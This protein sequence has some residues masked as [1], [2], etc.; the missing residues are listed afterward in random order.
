VMHWNG[1]TWIKVTSPSPGPTRNSL[2][3]VTAVS[4]SDA[5]AAGYYYTST[6]LEKT[7]VL[8]WNGTAWTKVTSPSPGPTRNSLSA[9]TAVSPSDIWAVGGYA[10][11]SSGAARTLVLHWNGTAWTKVASPNPGSGSNLQGVSALSPSDAWAAGSYTTSTG[12]YRTLVL[13]WNGTAWTKVASPNPSSGINSI[14]FGAV[15]ALSPSD[16][17]A[18]GYYYLPGAAAKTLVL[19]WNGTAWTK[20]ASPNPGSGGSTLNAVS[21]LS[22]SDAW[23]VG[24]YFT[25]APGS[26][27]VLHWN[28]T[29]WTK[30]ASPNPSSDPASGGNF[31]N[32]VSALS[33]SD[34]WAVG[35]YYTSTG[36]GKTLVLHWNGTAWTRS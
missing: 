5:W 33:P 20:V 17:W 31:L 35:V 10:T 7:L 14:Y 26:T 22:P 36:P 12:A 32:A 1:T 23:A 2:S 8:H 34:A 11:T 19:H 25:T 6:G 16:A 9:V 30:V 18:A 29:A 13:H 4:P 21:A 28:G 15:S 24:G 27:F 3:A